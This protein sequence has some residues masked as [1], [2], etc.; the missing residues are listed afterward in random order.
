MLAAAGVPARHRPYVPVVT[1]GDRVVW[2]GGYRADPTL[3]ATHSAQ[4][5]VLEVTDA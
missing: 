3:L 2:V 4:A 5:T 1:F